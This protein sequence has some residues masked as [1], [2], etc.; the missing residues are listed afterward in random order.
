MLRTTP[1]LYLCFVAFCN[2]SFSQTVGSIKGTVVD[3]SGAPIPSAQVTARRTDGFEKTTT[4]AANGSYTFDALAPGQYTVD[5]DAPSFRQLQPIV[6]TVGS[7]AI[8]ANIQLSIAATKQE[9]TVQDTVGPVIATDPSQNA[10][11]L[12][13][14]GDDMQAL[15]DDPDDLQSDLEALAGPAAG[16]NGGTF[17]VDGFS[18]G[19]A[20]LPNKEA[21]REIR[22]NQNPFSPEYDA[23]GFGRIEILTKP[24]ADQFRGSASFNYGD[25]ALNSRNPFAQQKAPFDLKDYA[26]NVGG[27][28]G[29]KMSFL[30]DFDDREIHNGA[31]LNAVVLDPSSLAIV[32][33]FT[34]VFS[35]PLGRLRYSSRLDY[36][37]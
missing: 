2:T 14:H 15:S 34:Q 32:S 26:G 17:F 30:S 7:R 27:P 28:L 31:I 29:K 18:A 23:I 19:D 11:A 4:S 1:F 12:V 3:Q 35:S 5:A 24:G 33:P 20:P 37:L 22:V 21:I 25:A 10:S 16:P 13:M 9:I 8:T 6:V 36:Q